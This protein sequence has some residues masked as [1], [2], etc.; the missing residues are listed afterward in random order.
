[1]FV[2]CVEFQLHP[3]WADEFLPLMNDQATNSLSLEEEC[4]RFDVLRKSTE[5]DLVFLYEVYTTETAFKEHLE[6]RH[7]KLFDAAVASM[8]KRKNVSTYDQLFSPADG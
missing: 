8:V 4:L 1:M 6:S 5:A 3:G 7:F 2:V